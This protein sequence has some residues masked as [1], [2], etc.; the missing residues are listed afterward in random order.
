[1][2]AMAGE[3]LTSFLSLLRLDDVMTQAMISLTATLNLVFLSG[4]L[5]WLGWW[6][7]GLRVK[8]RLTD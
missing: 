6:D 7:S 1:M 2:L 8:R 5:W 3:I 4:I